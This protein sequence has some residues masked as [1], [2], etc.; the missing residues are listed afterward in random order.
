MV[1]TIGCFCYNNDI[2]TGGVN[3]KINIKGDKMKK[4]NSVMLFSSVGVMFKEVSN[5]NLKMG[6]GR[7]IELGESGQITSNNYVI[8]LKEENNKID[9]ENFKPI[10]IYVFDTLIFKG[11][12]IYNNGGGHSMPCITADFEGDIFKIKIEGSL[13]K[14]MTILLDCE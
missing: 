13:Y 2:R 1:V 3:E 9:K 4:Q 8:F 11:N 10:E 6:R 5:E 12:G 14:E 7:N